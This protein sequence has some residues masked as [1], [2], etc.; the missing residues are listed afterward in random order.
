MVAAIALNTHSFRLH[1]HAVAISL[2]YWFLKHS[3]SKPI[4]HHKLNK[5]WLLH[6]FQVCV[7]LISMGH[8]SAS[9]Q[10]FQLT[11]TEVSKANPIL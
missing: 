6:T 2:L 3:S 7:A 10:I 8:A 5:A 4:M 9:Q 11:A 1:S